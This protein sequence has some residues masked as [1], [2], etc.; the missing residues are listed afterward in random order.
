LLFEKFHRSISSISFNFG[1]TYNMNPDQLFDTQLFLFKSTGLVL[2]YS[3]AKGWRGA[4]MKL[5]ALFGFLTLLI[6]AVF[7]THVLFVTSKS[8]EDVGDALSF[9]TCTIEAMVKMLA[10][11]YMRETYKSLLDSILEILRE[12]EF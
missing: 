9:L 5:F 10:F 3:Y 1:S 2:S 6:G 8:I 4:L 12:S 11:Y 7:H